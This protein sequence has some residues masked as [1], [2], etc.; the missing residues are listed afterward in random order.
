MNSNSESISFK[1]KKSMHGDEYYS[2][3]NVV[4]M[5]VP[6]IAESG[7]KKIWCPFDKEDSLFVQTFKEKGYDVTYG[8]IETGQDF[9][10]YSE[11]QGEVVVSNPPFSKRNAIFERLYQMNVPFALVMNLNGLF[12]SKKRHNLFKDN[13]IELLV[14]RGRMRFA[15][16]DKGMLNALNFQSIYVCHGLLNDQL[17]FSEAEFFSGKH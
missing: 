11:P 9:F 4:D 6:Y 3:Q 14:P 7:Y 12:D 5:I 8:H 13:G 17:V 16:K 2:P 1:I 10:D 15:L